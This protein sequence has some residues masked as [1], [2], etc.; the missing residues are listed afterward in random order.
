MARKARLEQSVP[1]ATPATMGL[2]ELTGQL[3]Q[4]APPARK[5]RLDRPAPKV[6]PAMMARMEPTGLMARKAPP[7]RPEQ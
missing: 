6:T 1:K 4:L 5:G 7:A 3:A 2:T